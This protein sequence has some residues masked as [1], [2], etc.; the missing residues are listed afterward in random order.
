MWNRSKWYQYLGTKLVLFLNIVM[1]SAAKAT[2]SSINELNLIKLYI[3][4]NDKIIYISF[5]KNLKYLNI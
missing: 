3:G 1:E 2:L 4:Y 5:M